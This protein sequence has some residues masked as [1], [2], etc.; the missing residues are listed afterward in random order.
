MNTTGAA[1]AIVEGLIR[2][3]V[4][5]FCVAP[6]SRSTP[7][8]L[9][10]A[11][12]PEAEASV[13]FDER[14]LAFYALGLAKAS[15]KPVA[16]LVTSGTA[17]G[18]LLPAVMEA[19]ADRV[20][21]ILLTADRPAE[22]RDC[23]ANQTTDQVKLFGSFVRWSVDLPCS[24]GAIPEGF[25]ERVVAQAIYQATRSGGGPVQ[26][27]CMF[28][29]PLLSAAE[30]VECQS[31]CYAD[32]MRLASQSTLEKWAKKL[33]GKGAIVLGTLAQ[34]QDLTPLYQL[35]EKLQWPILADSTS[36][37]RA[38]HPNLIAH[39]NT[40]LQILEPEAILHLGERFVSKPLLEWIARS[41][42]AHYLHVANHPFR[43]DPAHVVTDRLECDPMLFC[44]QILPCAASQNSWLEE[45]QSA[46]CAVATAVE[47]FFSLEP[48]ESEMQLMRTLASTLGPDWALF[49]SNSMPI[50]D[51]DHLFFP[52][53][54]TG[55][56]FANRGLS[57][58]DGNIATAIGI[59]EGSK[60]PTL[61]VLGDLAA[62]HDI[63]SL[64]QLK[65]AHYPVVF[66]IVNNGGGGIFSFLPIREKKEHFEKYVAAAHTLRFEHAARLFDIPY[67]TSISEA[68]QEKVSC[69]VEITTQREENY[70]QHL[71][72]Q[73]HLKTALS[74]SMVS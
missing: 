12:H 6:G 65:N 15:Q 30:T 2:Q 38:R 27:N 20:P 41:K 3:G 40:L 7:L 11:E 47:E 44:E 58:I 14:G 31:I 63:N 1:R 17:V 36:G 64:A 8:M 42:P 24:D 73:E 50:R 5:S 55:P 59:A 39:Y 71:R 70:Q 66:L 34:G 35:S 25:L 37:A 53:G 29:E 33:S 68:L 43:Q 10:I 56:I 32:S 28:R 26:M 9:A 18:N 22:L 16:I 49:L 21:L 69:L 74:S 46:S 61:A 19:A 57:G 60:R 72:L 52:S 23:G 13:H 4:R 45:W 67:K 51:A 62:L 48:Q 54:A